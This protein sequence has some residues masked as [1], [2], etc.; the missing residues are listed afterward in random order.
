[1]SS[2][3]VDV[4]ALYERVIKLEAMVNSHEGSFERLHGRYDE[5]LKKLDKQEDMLKSIFNTVNTVKWCFKVG[6]SVAAFVYLMSKMGFM[7]ALTTTL[8]LL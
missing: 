5:A 2:D 7:S 1:M 4:L 3:Q 8:G 6:I